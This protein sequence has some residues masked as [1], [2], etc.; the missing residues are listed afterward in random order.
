MYGT[1]GNFY[2]VEKLEPLPV[3]R[4]AEAGKAPFADFAARVAVAAKVM[5]DGP[6]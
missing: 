3:P 5:K 4:V 6:K 1:C 2:L